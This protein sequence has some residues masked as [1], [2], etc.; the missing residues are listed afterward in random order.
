[1]PQVPRAPFWQL[2]DVG[3]HVVTVLALELLILHV[4]P[5]VYM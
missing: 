3:C 5:G 1:M 2:V 4:F